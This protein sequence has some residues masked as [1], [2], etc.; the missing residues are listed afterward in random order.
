MDQHTV[1]IVCAE[2]LQLIF[3]IRNR[4]FSRIIGSSLTVTSPLRCGMAA[5]ASGDY[6]VLAWYLLQRQAEFTHRIPIAASAVEMI[7]TNTDS[8]FN[9][10][11][12]ILIRD[13][14]EVV[15]E[16]LRAE[17]NDRDAQLCPSQTTAWYG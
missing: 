15:A 1:E 10:C 7:D 8:V 6:H 12:G 17:G 3:D 14:T 4:T 9:E 13:K 2:Q 5:K 11:N 16:P